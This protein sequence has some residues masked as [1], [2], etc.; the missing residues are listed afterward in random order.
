MSDRFTITSVD[1]NLRAPAEAVYTNQVGDVVLE[2]DLYGVLPNAR[3][4]E[5]LAKMMGID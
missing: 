2:A 4:R 5:V 3:E 1:A